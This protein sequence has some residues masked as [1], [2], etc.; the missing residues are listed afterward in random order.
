MLTSPLA[1][2]FVRQRDAGYVLRQAGPSAWPRAGRAATPQPSASASSAP[3]ARARPPGAV[4][5]AVPYMR[6]ELFPLLPAAATS[7]LHALTL[8]RSAGIYV[9]PMSRVRATA[10]DIFGMHEADWTK[11]CVA[12]FD[13]G[14]LRTGLRTVYGE[15]TLEPMAKGYLDAAVPDYLTPNAE[16][17]DDWPWLQ[18]SLER[19]QDAEV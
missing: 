16:Y 4:V 1:G 17:S 15:Y 8:L 2:P 11:A 10:I 6:R 19:R 5:L 7:V 18:D 3:P 14:F 12:L 13:A 9:Y